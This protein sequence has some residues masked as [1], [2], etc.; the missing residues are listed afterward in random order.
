MTN[1]VG[2]AIGGGDTIL[3]FTISIEQRLLELVTLDIIGTLNMIFSAWLYL[4]LLPPY[5]V[6][7]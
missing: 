6:Q 1:N 3:W 7:H 2:L 5:H 4:V